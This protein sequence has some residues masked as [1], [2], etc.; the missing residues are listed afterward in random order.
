MNFGW[1]VTKLAIHDRDEFLVSILH[2]G[3][4]HDFYALTARGAI[5]KANTYMLEKLRQD[6]G[7][8]MSH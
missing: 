7:F 1:T 3:E 4:R 6:G 8:D 5:G 2:D